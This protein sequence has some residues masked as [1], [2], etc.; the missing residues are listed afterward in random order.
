MSLFYF[1]VMV[2]V[3]WGVPLLLGKQYIPAVPVVQ[4]VVGGL[5]FAALA[6][7]V[8]AILQGLGRTR[9]VAGAAIAMSVVC[10]AFV[11]I[12]SL[13]SGAIGAAWGLA[14]SFAIQAAA[15]TLRLASLVV[16]SAKHDC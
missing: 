16:G 4:V 7:V 6:S 11:T 8:A 12:G 1:A 9:Y 2:A 3:P 13:Q 15:L 10:I 5:A 14:L